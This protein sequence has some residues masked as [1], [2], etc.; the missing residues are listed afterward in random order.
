MYLLVIVSLGNSNI[1]THMHI[2]VFKQYTAT[3]KEKHTFPL[4]KEIIEDTYLSRFL[5]I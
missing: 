3:E 4:E 1:C 5:N 2:T